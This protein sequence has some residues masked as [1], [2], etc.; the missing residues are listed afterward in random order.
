MKIFL[1]GASG[2]TGQL[3]VSQLLRRG[4]HIVAVVRSIERLPEGFRTHENLSLVEASLLDLSDTKLSQLV[5]DCSAIASCLGQNISLK[6][7]Y[8]HPRWL[9]TDAARRLCMAVKANQPQTPVRYVLMNTV[10]NRNPDRDEELPLKD[11]IVIGLMRLVLP[12]QKDNEAA[13]VY[14]RTE[15]G[16]NDE[17]IEWVAVRPD[18]LFDEDTVTDYTL[19]PSP[20]SSAIFGDGKT[21]RINVAH[22][23]AELITDDTI[24]NKWKGQMPVIYN[25]VSS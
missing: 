9:V 6:G 7:M 19:H 11:R 10:G 23:M 3:L 20:T 22:F 17:V 13:A 25:K 21:S 4:H 18:A 1:A 2:S 8:G 15:I 16:Q 14:L 5:K 12:P 24:W